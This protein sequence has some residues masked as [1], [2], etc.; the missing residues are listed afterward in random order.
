MVFDQRI[1]KLINFYNNNQITEN[2]VYDAAKSNVTN[3]IF[4]S[5][6][7]E[8][9]KKFNIDAEVPKEYDMTWSEL[10]NFDGWMDIPAWVYNVAAVFEPTGIMSW[11][12]FIEAINEYEKDQ[13]PWNTVFL[14]LAS[15]AIIPVMG[16]PGKA[17]WGIL[18]ILFLPLKLLFKLIPGGRLLT[19]LSEKAINWC[20]KEPDA[21][22]AVAR[23]SIKPLD[24]INTSTGKKASEVYIEFLRKNK[25]LP[26][27]EIAKLK[28]TI[29]DTE[30]LIPGKKLTVDDTAKM[31][32]AKEVKIADDAAKVKA[33]KE[34]KAAEK[35]ANPSK[36]SKFGKEVLP[37]VV[38]GARVINPIKEPLGAA[39][40]KNAA[41]GQSLI[42]TLKK[43]GAASRNKPV[44]QRRAGFTSGK[45]GAIRP[46]GSY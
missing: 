38:G 7:S 9:F 32:A 30:K 4:N 34:A 19:S 15:I 40:D 11:P 42:D 2:I 45:I 37:A 24:K 31:K 21:M 16:K 23:N 41:D 3:A 33:A 14:I 39:I 8:V 43:L 36:L 29:D 6:L 10:S 1:E 13:G 18:K 28:K 26:E 44:L 17:V 20:K 27:E 35:L 22:A 46:G 12:S 25:L 5:K